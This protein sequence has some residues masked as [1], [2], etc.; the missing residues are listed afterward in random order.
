MSASLLDNE[1]LLRLSVFL[2]MLGVMALW[3]AARP[4]RARTLPRWLRWSNTLALAALGTLLVRL[5][6]PVLAVG[7]AVWAEAEGWGLLNILAVP[8]WLAI[9]A[10]LLLLDLIIYAQ[11]RVFHAVPA[12]WRLHRVHH[13]D[14]DLD[15]V[16]GLR[17][18]PLEIFLSMGIK[19]AAVAALGA[20]PVAVLLFEVILNACALFNHA[21]LRLPASVDR[22]VR[23]VLVTPD[24]HRVHHS[25]RREETDSNFGFS[26]SWWDRLLGTYRAQP[27]AGHEAMTLGQDRFRAPRDQWLDRLLLQPWRGPDA[28]PAPAPAPASALETVKPA[29]A[30]ARHR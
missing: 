21:N 12:L 9:I 15:V 23:W 16:T 17:F 25:T 19:L 20:P 4:R 26:L 29:D 11:H 10:S 28:A 14:T 8:G 22:T 27:V 18:H 24:M 5:L 2:G 1:A 7:L 3:E 13:A 30:A 6:L